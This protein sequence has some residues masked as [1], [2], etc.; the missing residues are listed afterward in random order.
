[1]PKSEQPPWRMST[2]CCGTAWRPPGRTPPG[3]RASPARLDSSPLPL[4][5]QAGNDL[6]VLHLAEVLVELPHRPEAP[7]RGEARH[8][9]GL[10]ADALQAVRRRHRHGADQPLG[11]PGPQRTERR[12]EEHT[13]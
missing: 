2:P 4:G 12:S 6:V 9:V 5:L 3:W 1:M 13:S 10:A 11:P 8:L 7:G